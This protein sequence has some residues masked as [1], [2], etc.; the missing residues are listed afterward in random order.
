MGQYT[1]SVA[2]ILDGA[3]YIDLL[4]KTGKTLLRDTYRVLLAIEALERAFDVTPSDDV[5]R[6]FERSAIPETAA[7]DRA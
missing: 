6:R 4:A 5:D 2:E 7:C 1:E 3:R